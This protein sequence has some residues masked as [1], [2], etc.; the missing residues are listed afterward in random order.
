MQSIKLLN[1]EELDRRIAERKAALDRFVPAV[2][3]LLT[4]H[5]EVLER[6][7]RGNFHTSID[8]E[9]RPFDTF[10]FLGSFGQSAMGGN[11][12]TIWHHPSGDMGEDTQSKCVLSVYWQVADFSSDEC[13]VS[14]FVS[15]LAW[16]NDLGS[17][18]AR[19]DEIF[20]AQDAAKAKKIRATEEVAREGAEKRS[21]LKDAER[22]GI[23]V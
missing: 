21:L 13:E 12:L 1:D 7:L 4:E 3:A 23:E 15:N 20:A 9:L 22:L 2:L 18:L 10:S 16:Q 6:E 19:K 8:K 5:G 14:R 11:T 17:L